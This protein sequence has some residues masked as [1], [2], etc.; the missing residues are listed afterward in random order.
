MLNM[1]FV[2]RDPKPT[3][4]ILVAE[5]AHRLRPRSASAADWHLGGATLA[6]TQV[7]VGHF[8]FVRCRASEYPPV[9][10]SA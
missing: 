3:I 9:F 5:A 4:N 2:T 7:A 10:S 6:R 1:S 8:R